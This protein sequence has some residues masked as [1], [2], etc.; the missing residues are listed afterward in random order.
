M[1]KKEANSFLG[2]K[3]GLIKLYAQY[4]GKTKAEAETD[5]DSVLSLL[6]NILIK[7]DEKKISI[8]NFFTMFLKKREESFKYCAL[9]GKK[10]KIPASWNI[11]FKISPILKE[12][13]NENLL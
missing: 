5:I 13:I 2:T 1:N 6:I 3:M 8:K 7:S 4:R 11:K 12:K 10:I 9:V